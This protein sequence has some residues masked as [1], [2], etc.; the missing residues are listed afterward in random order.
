[1]TDDVIGDDGTISPDPN[2]EEPDRPF[3]PWFEEYVAE[4]ATPE[5]MEH[6]GLLGSECAAAAEEIVEDLFDEGSEDLWRRFTRKLGIMVLDAYWH[7]QDGEIWTEEEPDRPFTDWLTERF[8]SRFD[9]VPLGSIGAM[10]RDAA[11]DLVDRLRNGSDS[12]GRAQ[13][14]HV[15]TALLY[16]SYIDDHWVETP[17]PY[18]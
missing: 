12:G 11:Y 2:V 7:E 3:E 4:K 14:V 6:A 10:C 17:A 1:M 5:V 13:F 9:T 18:R 8:D 15:F 16:R